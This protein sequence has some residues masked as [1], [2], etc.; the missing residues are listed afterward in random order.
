MQPTRSLSALPLPVRRALRKLGD[1]IRAARK[2]RRI[3]MQLMAERAFTSRQTIARVE[4]GDPRVSM[5]IYATV[6]FVLGMTE[7]LGELLDATKDPW[8]LELDEERLPERVRPPRR[9]PPRRD[10]GSDDL[11]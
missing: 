3:T 2:R 8:V 9:R 1:D 7:R 5:G 10:A 4:R 11:E 6:I